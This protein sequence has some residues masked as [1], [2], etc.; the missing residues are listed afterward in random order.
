MTLKITDAM[1]KAAMKAMP[2]ECFFLIYDNDMRAIVEAALQ[3]AAETPPSPYAHLAARTYSQAELDEAI[4]QEREGCAF[5]AECHSGFGDPSSI[6]ACADLIRARGDEPEECIHVRKDRYAALLRA[7]A[8]L[9]AI[10]APQ[11][12]MRGSLLVGGQK[13][14]SMKDDKNAERESRLNINE[15]RDSVNDA[16]DDQS[17]EKLP[18]DLIHNEFPSQPIPLH[19]RN[20]LGKVQGVC[21]GVAMSGSD[22]PN[23]DGA[24]LELSNEAQEILFPAATAT[25]GQSN[26]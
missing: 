7:E 24:L 16:C 12:N 18:I 22:H 21:M 15:G 10:T 6:E 4:R 1:V 23:P 26:E 14:N 19:V 5:A 2:K 17:A 11:P 3:S 25:E 9:A 13:L 8:D 20:F